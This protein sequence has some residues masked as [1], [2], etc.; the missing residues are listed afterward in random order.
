M[1]MSQVSICF[2]LAIVRAVS[3]VSLFALGMSAT[4]FLPVS[5]PE[6]RF[7]DCIHV[8][9]PN[10]LPVQ[11]CDPSV[12]L[13]SMFGRRTTVAMVDRATSHPHSRQRHHHSTIS[14]NRF[15]RRTFFYQLF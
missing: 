2:D 8:W 4:M 11:D 15:R 9:L 3:S 12:A 7:D 13:A 1:I 5:V 10:Y 14:M 6:L